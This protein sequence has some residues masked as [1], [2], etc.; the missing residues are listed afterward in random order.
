VACV[1]RLYYREAGRDLYKHY[2]RQVGRD[3]YVQYYREPGLDFLWHDY[4][5][6]GKCLSRQ[7]YRGYNGS[8]KA[9]LQATWEWSK[10][11]LLQ[12]L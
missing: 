10:E 7:Y 6:A 3:V 9:L 4:C 8:I 12:S 1:N 11:A 2:Y 5:Q